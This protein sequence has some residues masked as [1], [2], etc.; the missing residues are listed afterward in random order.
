MIG[1]ENITSIESELANIVKGPTNQYDTE[2]NS[3]PRRS[4]SQENEF[5]D[6]GHE[7]AIPRQE[8]FLES[9]ETFTNKIT[10][11]LSQE[12]DSMLSMMSMM[13]QVTEQ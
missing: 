13:H 1:N 12:M 5:G 11:R 4:S 8:R 3:H 7:N 6:F 9:M 10:L 2:C